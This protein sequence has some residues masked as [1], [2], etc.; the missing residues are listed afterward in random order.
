VFLC[1]GI[2]VDFPQLCNCEVRIH[3]DDVL[4]FD[5]HT[6][7]V[8]IYDKFA[9]C[10][11]CEYYYDIRCPSYRSALAEYLINPTISPDEYEN[12]IDGDKCQSYTPYNYRSEET[13][14][15]LYERD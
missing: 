1:C 3:I 8:N 2:D 15:S 12:T 6:S 13:T 9:P 14:Y 11:G 10:S 7:N 4:D 5:K